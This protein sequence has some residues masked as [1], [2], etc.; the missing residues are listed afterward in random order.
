MPVDDVD[1]DVQEVGRCAGAVDGGKTAPPTPRF[2]VAAEDDVEDGLLEMAVE[3]AR[4]SSLFASFKVT[5]PTA[6]DEWLLGDGTVRGC[7]WRASEMRRP[8]ETP[9]SSS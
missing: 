3:L 6:D 8:A 9:R 7:T 4:L 5:D 2:V 1:D